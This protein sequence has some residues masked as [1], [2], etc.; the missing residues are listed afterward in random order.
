M[1]YQIGAG[2]LAPVFALQ[3]RYVRRVLP[4]LPE[5]EGARTGTRGAGRQIRVLL[6]GDSATAG[7]GAA[8]QDEALSGRLVGEL[9]DTFEVSWTLVARTGATTAG[10]ARHLARRP[11]AAYDVAVVWLG[12]NDVLARRPIARWLGDMGMLVDLLRERFGVR[13]LLVSGVPPMHAFPAL[14]Q[15]LRWYLGATARRFDR[16]LADWT[17]GQPDC[18]HLSLGLRGAD[19]AMLAEDGFHPGPAAYRQWA[20]ELATRIRAR[21]AQPVADQ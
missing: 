6:I 18:E 12:A 15:P 16:A 11:A 5:P 10:T 8:T 19:A 21:W 1:G 17:A 20:A 7:V 2:S 4:R 14:P 3:G 13:H 9:T